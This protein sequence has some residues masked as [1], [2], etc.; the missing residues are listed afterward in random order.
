MHLGPQMYTSFVHMHTSQ[1][2]WAYGQRGGSPYRSMT[3]CSRGQDPKC[4]PSGGA[5]ILP[6]Y[7]KKI[8]FQ[9]RF[10]F[11]I[12]ISGTCLTD[13]T[14][15]WYMAMAIW[16]PGR[17]LVPNPGRWQ[18]KSEPHDSN[19]NRMAAQHGHFGWNMAGKSDHTQFCPEPRKWTQ[20]KCPYGVAG[21]YIS[22]TG[23]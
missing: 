19:M 2:R 14:R 17:I 4:S 13:T 22:Q 20:E 6:V 16:W 18:L 12:S 11:D 15:F 1:K 5:Q 23:C 3:R 8:C 7:W 21:V 10:L 9:W